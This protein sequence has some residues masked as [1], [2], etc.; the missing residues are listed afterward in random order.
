MYRIW[1]FLLKLGIYILPDI[2]QNVFIPGI[3]GIDG[4]HRIL[5]RHDYAVL[6]ILTISPVGTL[7]P[8][9]E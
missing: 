6:S 4:Y 3:K 7:R 8:S 1:D 9:P 2:V 5:I